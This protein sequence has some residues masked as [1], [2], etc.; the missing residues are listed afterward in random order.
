ME[1][2]ANYVIIGL[3]TLATIVGAF[4]FVYW[5]ENLTGANA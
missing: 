3:F 2:R 1:T 5:F 4:S